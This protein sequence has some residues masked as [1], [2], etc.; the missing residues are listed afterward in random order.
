MVTG[1]LTGPIRQGV[2]GLPVRFLA[3]FFVGRGAN[4]L[5]RVS[6]DSKLTIMAARSSLT[7]FRSQSILPQPDRTDRFNDAPNNRPF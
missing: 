3:G 7:L 1:T 6:R 4:R 2:S 5:A